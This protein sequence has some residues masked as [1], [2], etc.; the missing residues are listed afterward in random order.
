MQMTYSYYA[1]STWNKDM[2]ANELIKELLAFYEKNYPKNPFM[3]VDLGLKD[4]K[5]YAKIDGNRQITIYQ[6]NEKDVVVKIE[7]LSYK[8]N[9]K[10]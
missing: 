10:K 8:F 7:D 1:W 9:K 2:H 4:I 5:A 3:E 6:Q